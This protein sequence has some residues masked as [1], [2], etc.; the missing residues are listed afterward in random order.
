MVGRDVLFRVKSTTNRSGEE[1]LRLDDV[2]AS[3]ARGLK[4]L[5][6]VSFSVHA[7]EVFGIAGVDGNGQAEL[8]ET[9]AGLRPVDTGRISLLGADITQASVSERAGA[10]GIA[11]VPED[12]HRDG[13]VLDETVAQNM[14]LRTYDRAPFAR[15]GFFDRRA[16]RDH[17]ERLASA[18]DV[19]LQSVDQ[20]V[21]LL[22]GGN[23]Q[24]VILARELEGE[25]KVLVVAQP[26]KGLDVGAIEFV[27]KQILIQRDRGVAVLYVSTELEHLLDVCDRVG[28]MFRGRLMDTIDSGEATPERIG[29]LMAGVAA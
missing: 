17:A 15:F 12:R 29:L 6:Q 22:S 1:V 11:Y 20:E 27:Q 26:T 13:L 3:N 19:R 10:L 16:I 25:P 24:K 4:A 18:F 2:S 5:D 9:I 28:V 7:G 14:I 21:R 8:A 23:Q